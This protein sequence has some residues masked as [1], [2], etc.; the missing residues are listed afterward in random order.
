M[1]HTAQYDTVIVGGGPAGLTAALALTRYRHRTL[2]AE[3]PAAPRNAASRGVHGMIGLEGATPAE[4]RARAWAE[5]DAYGLAERRDI[6]ADDIAPAPE[7]RFRTV[8]G[9]GTQVWSRTVLLATGVIDIHPEDVEGFAACWSRTVIHCP[10][11]IGWENAERTWGLVADDPGYAEMAATGFS[12][13]S[14]DVIAIA[15]PGMDRAEETRRA[16]R[17]AGSDLVQGEIARLHHH[18]GDLYAVDMADGTRIDRQTLLW[19]PPQRQVPLVT[20]LADTLGLAL[21]DDGFVTIGADQQTSVPGLYAAGDLTTAW[22]QGAMNAAGAGAKAA[23]A[24]HFA[25]PA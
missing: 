24:I 12:A 6:A 15:P 16:L 20:R 8:L 2:V 11:C 4:V 17:A 13:W 22:E 14:A 1:N 19:A 21:D 3:S 7:G 10:F 5:L 25:H 23:D 9:D 18:D